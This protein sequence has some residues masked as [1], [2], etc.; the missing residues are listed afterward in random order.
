MSKICKCE[1]PPF[2]CAHQYW[3]TFLVQNIW[4]ESAWI[5][6]C[7]VKKLFFFFFSPEESAIWF[8]LRNSEVRF[9]DDF[10]IEKGK[11]NFKNLYLQPNLA[12]VKAIFFLFFEICSII[13][14]RLLRKNMQNVE[15]IKQKTEQYILPC[16]TAALETCLTKDYLILQAL[17]CIWRGCFLF[18]ELGHWETVSQCVDF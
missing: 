14:N 15:Q 13:V 6:N 3:H 1:P 2:L 17:N 7:V 8:T 9:K 12:Q 16:H 5:F 18:L 4:S 11:N 10:L